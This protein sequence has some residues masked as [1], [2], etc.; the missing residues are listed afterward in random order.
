MGSAN[1]V[2]TIELT[3]DQELILS[4]NIGNAYSILFRG[5]Q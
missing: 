1:E 5:F 4:E 2:K 3:E